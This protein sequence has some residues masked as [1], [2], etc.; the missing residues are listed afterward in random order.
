M[1]KTIL[2]FVMIFL[3][4]PIF[5]LVSYVIQYDYIVNELCVNR[6]RPD[7]HCNGKCHLMKEMANAA[8]A[9]KQADKDYKFPVLEQISFVTAWY[10][11]TL[12][13]V[14]TLPV[15]HSFFYLNVYDYTSVYDGFRPP[16]V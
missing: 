11:V 1:K 4:K 9:E 10:E 14:F 15:S 13:V 5:P 6:D 7:L 12:P 3:V 2:I 16:V 8:A